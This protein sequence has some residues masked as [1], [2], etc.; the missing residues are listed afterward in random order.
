MM[1]Y[2]KTGT[3]GNDSTQD[4][5]QQES[6]SCTQLLRLK[7]EFRRSELKKVLEQKKNP[8]RCRHFKCG[9]KFKTENSLRSHSILEHRPADVTE[10][11]QYVCEFDLCNLLFFDKR[12]F[13]NHQK[14]FHEHG[15]MKCIECDKCFRKKSSLEEHVITAHDKPIEKKFAC[16]ACDKKFYNRTDL[17]QHSKSHNKIVK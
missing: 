8:F 7:P 4:D 9:R 14:K 2:K 16:T 12:S 3:N 1:S 13:K 15:R 6:S 10:E 17:R 11:E 5:Y